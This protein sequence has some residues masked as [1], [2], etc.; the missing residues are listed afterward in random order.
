MVVTGDFNAGPDSAVHAAL[1]GRGGLRDAWHPA[2][3]RSGPEGTFHAFT[4]RAERRID[5]ILVR[6]F[7]V[8]A[9]HTIDAN[10]NGRYP[11]D[12]FPVVAELAFP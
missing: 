3:T 12:H 1:A 5:W 7:E 6:G 8:R 9:V 10:E 4:G 11:S 2:A